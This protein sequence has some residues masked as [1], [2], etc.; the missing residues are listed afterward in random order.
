MVGRP[1]EETF[2]AHL[3]DGSFLNG[4]DRDRWRLVSVDWPHA[5]IAVSAGEREGGPKDFAFR[6]DVSNYPKDAPTAQ[7]W[8]EKTDSS[9]AQA[10]RPVGT[11]RVEKAFCWYKDGTC[12]Y[13]PCDR[14]ALD[15][16]HAA[17]LNQH[18]EMIWKP[19]SDITH[20]LRIIH[21]LL[22]SKDYQGVRGS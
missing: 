3:E 14:N 2:R 21:D 12:L 9:L 20:Y 15:T 1:D 6:F 13:L 8:D 11:G 17:W 5:V 19:T 18:P 4:V 10:K 16:G 7:P 22:H